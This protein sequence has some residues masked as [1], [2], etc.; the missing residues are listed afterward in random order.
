MRDLLVNNAKLWSG[1]LRLIL[2]GDLSLLTQPPG[3][4]SWKQEHCPG[5]G[6]GATG[7]T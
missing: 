6:E 1:N 4:G 3:S 7:Q 5:E 2:V